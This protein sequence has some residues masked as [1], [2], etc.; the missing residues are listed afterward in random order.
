MTTRV[1][2][3][4]LAT[5]H[6]FT[7]GDDL[8]A[9]LLE[10]VAA[11]GLDLRDGDV[12]CVA[13]KA[14]SLVE[15][16]LHPLP[17]GD[18]K[19]ARRRLARDLATRIVVD[20]PGVLVTETPHGFVCANGGIDASNV[21]GDDVALLLPDDPDASA[22]RLRREVDERTGARIGVVV[23]DTFGRPWRLGQTEVALGVAGTPAL[24]D[25]RG[26]VDL[27]GRT[28]EVTVAAIAD[29]VAAAADLVRTKASGTP[30]VLVRGLPDGPPGTGRDLLR[31]A[32]TDAFRA[33]GPT[34]AEHAVAG[35]R[36][37]RRFLPDQPVDPAVVEAAVRAAATAPAPHHTRPWRFV[38][39][40]SPTRER[41][42]DAMAQQWRADLAGDGTTADVIERRIARSDAVLRDAPE[43]LAP[44]VV[45]DG[46]HDY[47][48]DRRTGAER[49]LFM[50]AGGAALQ[51]LQVVLAAH[52][53][54]A[55]WISSTAFC[56][57]TVREV[58][59]LDPTW[60]PLGILAVGHPADRP[61]PRDAP[62]VE[63][64]L[65]ER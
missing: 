38:R 41:L 20:T 9:T 53:L 5:P 13:S 49:D 61:P 45:L 7:A 51:N 58:L 39:L 33:G 59:G 32:A 65:L 63:D 60:Q 24:R 34:A 6:R 54:G 11:A 50:L 40:T 35:R 3:V 56:A 55:A 62:H 16:A 21:P 15:G 25:E 27:Q 22:E 4:G 30:F 2:L 17:A 42:L 14:V 37:I 36:T 47:P 8:A 12:V 57:P 1:D 46:A 28:L 48:D 29:E 19:T 31:P 10:A 26:G 43:L 64:L 52:G 23:T 44:F 18:A